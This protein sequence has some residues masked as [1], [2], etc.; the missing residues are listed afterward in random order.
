MTLR[1][2]DSVQETVA[3]PSGSAAF[4]ISTTAAWSSGYQTFANIPSIATGDT[5]CY[6]AWDSSGH[7]E[8][9]TGT[10]ASGSLARAPAF[11][12][13]GY[14]VAATFSGSVTLICA[15]DAAGIL[16]AR[17]GMW[18]PPSG[19]YT[20]GNFYMTPAMYA[21]VGTFYANVATA[22]PWMAQATGTI[23][24]L[25]AMLTSAGSGTWNLMLAIYTDNGGSPG[26]LL[27]SGI[28]QPGAATGVVT[29]TLS[30]G[31]TVT[32]GTLY[33]LVA[34]SDT[35]TSG[36]WGMSAGATNYMPLLQAMLGL[37]SATKFF[38]GVP[39]ASLALNVG[40]FSLPSNNASWGVPGPYA[41]TA[42][43]VGF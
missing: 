5:V 42:V 32:P 1:Y 7:Y 14:G 37:S 43:I 31:I 12:T 9:G 20:P 28:V 10:Y 27:G 13:A 17:A 21:T 11:S 30:P 16:A 35:T 38:S 24:S 23:Q 26:T 8:S 34:I 18:S 39:S 3:A 33:W 4:A 2:A 22:M 15:I 6:G 29:A 25:S 19:A 36:K 41:G 40:S